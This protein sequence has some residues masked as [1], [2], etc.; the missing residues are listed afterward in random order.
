[1]NRLAMTRRKAFLLGM[2]FLAVVE[3]AAVKAFDYYRYIPY[4]VWNYYPDAASLQDDLLKR[5]PIGSPVTWLMI[6]LQKSGMD[7]AG[8]PAEGAYYKGHK[9]SESCCALYYVESRDVY[10]RNKYQTVRID[11]EF[12]A[13]YKI[14]SITVHMGEAKLEWAP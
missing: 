3:I 6:K 5:F 12:N 9:N 10:I 1:M 4:R 14:T 13:A 2:I 11:V 8:D 7:L